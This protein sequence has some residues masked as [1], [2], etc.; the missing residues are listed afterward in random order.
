MI[1]YVMTPVVTVHREGGKYSGIHANDA[2]AVTELWLCNLT[3]YDYTSQHTA[4]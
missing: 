1:T 4:K 2:Q 3:R